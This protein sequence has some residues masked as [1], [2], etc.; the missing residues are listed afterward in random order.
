[1]DLFR[2]CAFYRQA[3]IHEK[4]TFSRPFKPNL[5]YQFGKNSKKLF[6]NFPVHKKACAPLPLATNNNN[7]RAQNDKESVV[8]WSGVET[9]QELNSLTRNSAVSTPLQNSVG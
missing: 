1:M 6:E 9:F 4:H 5:A 3:L 7:E 8:L 2:Y